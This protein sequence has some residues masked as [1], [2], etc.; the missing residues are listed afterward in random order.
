VRRAVL[1]LVKTMNTILLVKMYR[2]IRSLA[3]VVCMNGSVMIRMD[4]IRK[5]EGVT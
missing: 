2:L 4:D 3:P 1:E 5:P